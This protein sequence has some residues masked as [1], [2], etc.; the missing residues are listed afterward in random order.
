MTAR[1]QRLLRAAATR[2]RLWEL[3]RLS[4][5]PWSWWYRWRARRV[6]PR[7]RSRSEDEVQGHHD[8]TELRVLNGGD[9][10]MPAIPDGVETPAAQQHWEDIWTSSIARYWEPASDLG[11][12]KRYI[13]TFDGWMK[14]RV[15]ATKVPLVKGSQGQ[16]RPNP[17]ESTIQKLAHELRA[18]ESRYGLTPK[19]RVGLGVDITSGIAAGAQLRRELEAAGA[20]LE[21]SVIGAAGDGDM[22]LEPGE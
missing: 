12:L 4:R 6:M 5:W 9:L 19:D 16:L 1:R 3:S 10:F 2:R 18:F 7:P 13:L 17:I 8:R 20:D 15:I 11:A 22:F 14:A 21:A